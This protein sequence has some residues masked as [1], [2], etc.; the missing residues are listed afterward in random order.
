FR[1]LVVVPPNAEGTYSEFYMRLFLFDA[2]RE[3]FDEIVD[4]AASPVVN[5]GVRLTVIL[6]C[7]AIGKDF[8]GYSVWV[9]VIVE[10][11]GVEIVMFY[12]FDDG[13]KHVFLCSRMSGIVIPPAAVLHEPLRMEIERMIRRECDGVFHAYPV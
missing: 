4:V 13:L 9:K 6:I 5:V 8:T 2:S 1:I 10:V 7:A 12:G 11:H 3:F